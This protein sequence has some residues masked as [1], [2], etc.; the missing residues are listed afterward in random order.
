MFNINYLSVNRR[1]HFS[2]KIQFDRETQYSF[3]VDYSVRASKYY[4]KLKTDNDPLSKVF[5]FML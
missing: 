2:S 5:N 4:E 3:K 1:L